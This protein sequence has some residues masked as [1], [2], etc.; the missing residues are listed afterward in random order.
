LAL[1]EGF[2]G[3]RAKMPV[4]FRNIPPC[5]LANPIQDA[6]RC[7]DRIADHRGR[8]NFHLFDDARLAK[9]R[10][11]HAAD[12]NEA[13]RENGTKN[14]PPLIESREYRYEKTPQRPGALLAIPDGEHPNVRGIVA[15]PST[16]ELS[17][18]CK[19]LALQ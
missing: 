19:F 16:H 10:A 4:W 7:C 15:H 1:E 14:E 9:P 11:R 8:K 6:E 17:A 2:D 13:V 18:L 5:P 12:S 3:N